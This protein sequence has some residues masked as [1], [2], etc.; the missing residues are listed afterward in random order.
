MPTRVGLALLLISMI[1]RPS[2][3]S[4]IKAVLPSAER[5]TSYAAPEVSNVPVREGL[6]VLLISII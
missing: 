2:E 1:S 3:P 6:A 4:A 5:V